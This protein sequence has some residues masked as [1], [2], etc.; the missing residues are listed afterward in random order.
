M[1]RTL[2]YIHNYIT[3]DFPITY[4]NAS[5]LCQ[6]ECACLHKTVN[7]V[8]FLVTSNE[9]TYQKGGAIVQMYRVVSITKRGNTATKTTY[10]LFVTFIESY[11]L[12]VN[13]YIRQTADNGLSYVCGGHLESLNLSYQ[14]QRDVLH[15]CIDCVRSMFVR[16]LIIRDREY[17]PFVDYVSRYR[18]LHIKKKICRKI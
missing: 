4:R 7:M 12:S 18:Y 17:N 13:C 5:V 1:L 9:N 8:V 14:F 15:S 16:L 6:S 11:G 2:I 3:S 10:C